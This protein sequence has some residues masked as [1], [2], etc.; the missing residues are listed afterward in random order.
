MTDLIC[1][2]D[3][4]AQPQKAIRK[5]V[6]LPPDLA[7]RVEEFREAIGASSESDALK[8]L[9]EDGLK[10][11]DRPEDLLRR[12]EAMTAN[13]Q[14][15]GEIVTFTS[16]HPLVERSVVDTDALLL[17]LKTSSDHSAFRFRFSRPDRTWHWEINI[18]EFEAQWMPYSLPTNDKQ[19]GGDLDD[20]IPF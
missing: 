14:S 1:I 4:M 5:L 7:A 17:F 13:R 12:C 16:D 8:M 19:K 6:T 10:L 11:K 9:I 2:E 18:G 15:I 3:D 20:D